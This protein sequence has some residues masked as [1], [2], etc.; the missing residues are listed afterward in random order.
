MGAR[1]SLPLESALQH[2]PEKNRQCVKDGHGSEDPSPSYS[3]FLGAIVVF[4]YVLEPSNAVLA[5][6][7]DR[8][9]VDMTPS[10]GRRARALDLMVRP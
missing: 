4:L 7:Q 6:R 10:A 8:L 3:L 1:S 5:S 9:L 2:S